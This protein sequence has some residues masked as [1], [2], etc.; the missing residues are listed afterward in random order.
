MTYEYEFIDGWIIRD[1]AGYSLPDEVS[2]ATVFALA[3]GYMGSRGAPEFCSPRLQGVVG[4]YVNGL[5]DSPTGKILD[6]E[7]VNL[8]T[9]TAMVLE[10]DGEALTLDQP[11]TYVGQLDIRQGL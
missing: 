9:W 1:L 3:N 4:T 2:K 6:R 11:Q 5:Y 8:P 7:I 10:V